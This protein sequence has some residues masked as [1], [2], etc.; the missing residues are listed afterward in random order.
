VLANNPHYL[1]ALTALADIKWDAQDRA[2]AA[3][4]YRE[5]ADTTPDSA[6]A[7]RAKDRA[8]QAEAA[9]RAPKPAG[10]P[11]TP[12]VSPPTSDEPP[13]I[14]TSDLPGFKR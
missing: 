13:E 6:Q 10:R 12:P 11:R 3:K 7:Q 9:P 5:I 14:D 2:G 4:I 8:A 1:P